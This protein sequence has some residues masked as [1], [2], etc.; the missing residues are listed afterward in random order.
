MTL[1]RAMMFPRGE[2]RRVDAL[3]FARIDVG[4]MLN[5]PADGEFV[6]EIM[7]VRDKQGAAITCG[8]IDKRETAC[9]SS[10]STFVNLCDSCGSCCFMS[11]EAWKS[12]SRYTHVLCRSTQASSSC[13]RSESRDS[14]DEA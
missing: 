4:T 1:M 8:A 3:E 14:H 13:L 6:E 9:A 10:R 12:P 5:S 7:L 2:E 11:G